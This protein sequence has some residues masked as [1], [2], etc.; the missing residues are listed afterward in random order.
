MR[1]QNEV[2]AESEN[3]I[4]GV[5][6]ARDDFISDL[7]VGPSFRNK[8]VGRAL[9]TGCGIQIRVCWPALRAR[10]RSSTFPHPW[11]RAKRAWKN[12]AHRPRPYEAFAARKRFSAKSWSRSAAF[13]CHSGAMRSIEPGGYFPVCVWPD[14][15]CGSGLRPPRNDSYKK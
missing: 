15:D 4:I 2:A 3:R 8:G 6:L 11:V 13:T 12:Q 14:M 5:I 7:R 1:W 10:L 9:L